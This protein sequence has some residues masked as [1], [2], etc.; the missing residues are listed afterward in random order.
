MNKRILALLLSINLLLI[1]PAHNSFVAG[2]D[3]TDIVTTQSN[4]QTVRKGL[5]CWYYASTNSEQRD[6][7][8]LKNAGVSWIYNWGIS[9]DVATEAN[10]AG[11][12]YVPQI[13]GVSSI[14]YL[15]TLKEGKE[16]GLYRN[17][18]T[19][20]E[21]D[22]PDQS[23][24]TVDRAIKLWPRLEETGLRLGS[25]AGAA[26]EDAWVEQFMAKAKENG[27]RVDFLTVHVYQDFTDPTS[28][29]RLKDAL[30]RLHN[31]Y[32]IPLWITEIGNV[33]VSTQWAGYK[34]SNPMSH[35]L[36]TKYIKEACEM[37]ES[38]DFVERYAWFVDYSSNIEGTAYTRL[39]NIEEGSLTE[40]GLAY[41]NIVS[42]ISP[43][44]T[45]ELIEPEETTTGV[46]TTKENV[47]DQTTTKEIS[48][49]SKT[50]EDNTDKSTTV[51]P[52]SGNSTKADSNNESVTAEDNSDKA[53]SE[54]KI[55]KT[56]IKKIRVVK[57][58]LKITIKKVKKADG[59][60]IQWSNNKKFKKSKS[61]AVKSIIVKS[62]TVRSTTAYLKKNK[63]KRG[64]KYYFRVKA[65]K[66]Y[67]KKIKYG[68]WGKTEKYVIK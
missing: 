2:A 16:K 10:E 5:C 33:D 57:K 64:V 58:K 34:L 45:D 8:V 23:N 26:V 7:G 25:P 43:M 62:T 21:P 13:W 37:M 30:T 54:I 32:Q 65:Y 63:F 24:M 40:E 29:G 1:I 41:K 9:N 27:Y 52:I 42:D 17:L 66:M 35:E 44:A 11:I 15:Q 12:E 50:A 20:N 36:A 22:L 53:N 59:Y 47:A 38:L 14:Q 39:F 3:N 60:K 18:L 68:K 6:I 55:K 56:T 4:T 61:K 51:Q 49:E 46:I 28:V 31:K 19:F 67:N 48:S